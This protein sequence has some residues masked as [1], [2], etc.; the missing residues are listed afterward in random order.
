MAQLREYL[1]G[2]SINTVKAEKLNEALEEL[3]RTIPRTDSFTIQLHIDPS[4]MKALTD[5]TAT[6]VL[7]IVREAL[8]NTLRHANATSSTLSLSSTPE[9][10]RLDIQDDGIGFDPNATNTSGWGL[11]NMAARAKKLDAKFQLVSQRG[12]GTRISLDIPTVEH[13]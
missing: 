10:L 11:R 6:H 1:E 9:G 12:G 5:Q 8:T 2:G 13:A 4:T 3:V 7:H